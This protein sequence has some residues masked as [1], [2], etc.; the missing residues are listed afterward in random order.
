M[1]KILFFNTNQAWGGG[2]K[3]HLNMAISLKA[4]NYDVYIYCYQ[5]SKLAKRAKDQG[6]KVKEIKLSNLSFLNPSKRK[7]VQS[8]LKE[9]KPH[10]IIMNLPRD[11]KICAPLAKRLK[12]KKVIYRR[13]MPHP[14]K[15]TFINRYIFSKVDTFIA[16]SKEIKRSIIQNFPE[17]EA[18]TKIIFN[19]VI[20]K[21]NQLSPLYKPFKLGNLGRLVEQKGQKDLIEVAKILKQK[22]FDFKLNIAGDGPLKEELKELISKYQLDKNVILLGYQKPED[23]FSNIDFFVFTSHFE[24][25]AN[26]LIEALQ[27]Q[28]VVIAYDISSNPEVIQNGTNGILVKHGDTEAMANAIIELS[29]NEKLCREMQDHAKETILNLFNYTNKVKEVMELIENE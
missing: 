8:F 5:D 20:P 17:L 14:F 13:G 25:S 2:E 7:Q 21:E 27:Y 15:R 6:L 4:Q 28:K 10:A 11:V 9:I 22:N 23:V 24:G 29:M 3:W 12:V 1:K 18:K 26:A 16:N 19:G